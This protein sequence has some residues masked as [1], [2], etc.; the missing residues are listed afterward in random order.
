MLIQ[1]GKLTNTRNLF[2]GARYADI[3][4]MREYRYTDRQ[5]NRHTHTPRQEYRRIDIRQD[6][7]KHWKNRMR[8][9]DQIAINETIKSR[10]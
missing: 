10:L 5:A 1:V 4:T 2:K 8:H 9:L 6:Q 7:D 3:P